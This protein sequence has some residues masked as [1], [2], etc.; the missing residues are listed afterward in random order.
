LPT[1]EHTLAALPAAGAPAVWGGVTFLALRSGSHIL[2]VPG[3][4][5]CPGRASPLPGSPVVP[6]SRRPGVADVTEHTLSL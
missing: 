2:P 4:S 6:V 5:I 1:R 3:G